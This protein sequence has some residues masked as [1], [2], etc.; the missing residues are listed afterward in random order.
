MGLTPEAT[1]RAMSYRYLMRGMENQGNI[2]YAISVIQA[3]LH[4]DIFRDS[5]EEHDAD[6]PLG[7]VLQTLRSCTPERVSISLLD[8]FH[9]N[10]WDRVPNLPKDQDACEF[11]D[12]LLQSLSDETQTVVT[13]TIDLEILD[14]DTGESRSE[15]IVPQHT[16]LAIEGG[17]SIKELLVNA[18]KPKHDDF[19]QQTTP[20]LLSDTT[21]PPVLILKLERYAELGAVDRTPININQGLIWRDELGSTNYQLR[22]VVCHSGPNGGGH[23]YTIASMFDHWW[24]FNDK[25]VTVLTA[26]RNEKD[27]QQ[28]LRQLDAQVAQQAYIL[29]YEQA[30]EC[31]EDDYINFCDREAPPEI[32][33][34]DFS[35]MP[36]GE[37]ASWIRVSHG[38]IPLISNFAPPDFD[39]SRFSRS[40]QGFIWAHPGDVPEKCV[41]FIQEPAH[42]KFGL[43]VRMFSRLLTKK[44]FH[45]VDIGRLNAEAILRR[46]RPEMMQ[47]TQELLKMQA[48]VLMQLFDQCLG[49]PED[50]NLVDLHRNIAAIFGFLH[51]DDIDSDSDCD[52]TPEEEMERDDDQRT[53]IERRMKELNINEFS[54]AV[55]H[56]VS[57]PQR[58]QMKLSEEQEQHQNIKR[59]FVADFERFKRVDE[60]DRDFVT[61]WHP[62]KAN[63]DETVNEPFTGG[64]I[65]PSADEWV[66]SFKTCLNWCSDLR[67]RRDIIGPGRG[68]WREHTQKVDEK[69]R[70]VIFATVLDHPDMKSRDRAAVVSDFMG[71]GFRISKSTVNDVLKKNQF[72]VQRTTFS[73]NPRNSYALIMLRRIWAMHMEEIIADESV[74]PVFV[75]EAAV[76]LC[77]KKRAARGFVGVTP[78]VP[79]TLSDNKKSVLAA[80]IPGFGCIWHMEDGS[81]TGEVYATFI[82]QMADMIRR[83]ICNGNTQI[84]MIHDNCKIHE[85]AEVAVA[86][87]ES[88]LNVVPTVPY[89]PQLNEPVE[90]F[91]GYMKQTLANRMWKFETSLG[92]AHAELEVEW[93]NICRSPDFINLT[94]SFYTNWTSRLRLAVECVPFTSEHITRLAS[95]GANLGFLRHHQAYRRPHN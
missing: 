64:L 74:L 65:R 2:C 21:L 6:H 58:P 8:C 44:Q 31:R 16:N 95:P 7:T 88:K 67:S 57:S 92:A 82:R 83:I 5:I 69:V 42:R 23:F 93:A 3:L 1:R 9:W 54:E 89:S 13:T 59:K 4:S 78:I 37:A 80:V 68:G 36:A 12:F 87:Q 15:I 40:A 46:I 25:T 33:I 19:N 60:T 71:N 30:P 18:W 39:V 51:P 70:R 66:P 17:N 10:F 73:P 56:A 61:R 26:A 38:S 77:M 29:V 27:I 50:R 47:E 24:L 86:V 52:E 55:E 28:H 75:D 85:T 90:S 84:L 20:H 43:T 53:R 11:L 34:R 79:G 49:N 62:S 35:P 94:E 48:D 91:F 32:M 63:P 22:S 41:N 45:E 14:L 72:T 81:I 76:T